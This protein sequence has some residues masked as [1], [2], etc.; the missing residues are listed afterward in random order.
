MLDKLQPVKG[1]KDLITSEYTKHEHIINTAYE[2]GRLY[3]FQSFSTPIIEYTEVFNRTLGDS[4]DVID[5]EMYSFTDKG[6]RSIS[7]RPEF[8]AGIMR[9]VI[10][11]NLHDTGLPLRYFSTGPLFRYDNPQAGRQRQFHQINFELIGCESEFVDA[12]MIKLATDILTKLSIVNQ[13]VLEVNSLG[14][15]DSRLRYKQALVEYFS[16]YKSELSQESQKRLIHNPLRVLDSKDE[17]D[18]RI[19]ASA[20]QI[21]HYYTLNS[22]I[23]INKVYEYLE[24]LGINYVVNSKLVRGLD[25]YCHTVFEYKTNKLGAQ[26]AV[27]AGGRYDNLFKQMGGR[28]MPGKTSLPSFGFAGGIER[29]A[30]MI[31][32]IKGRNRPVVIMVLSYTSNHHA[33][34][35]L[36]QLRKLNI[37][38]I[39]D[40]HGKIS[41]R[42]RRAND[43]NAS[44]VIFIGSD[45][46]QNKTYKVK[47]LDSRDEIVIPQDQLL[48]YLSN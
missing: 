23:H 12:E 46:I 18:Q 28:L 16:K 32:A 22:Q 9:A 39:I 34:A 43:I 45:E 7:L 25:Y 5:K 27:L 21:S 8:T 35:L 33:I 36:Q 17:N 24:I 31:A 15:I 4:S 40:M 37:I 20:P 3:G 26:S 42:L 48:N 30:L 6:G 47:N 19:S 13:V 44:T 2:L 10:H 41:K 29:L 1:T 38:S 11:H 14:C